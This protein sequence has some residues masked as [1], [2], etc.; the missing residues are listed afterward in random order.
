MTKTDRSNYTK[1]QRVAASR[2]RVYDALTTLDGLRGW[3]TPVVSGSGA[4]GGELKF[5]FE[6]LD[7]EIVM[8]VEAATRPTSVRW[9]CVGHS[10]LPEWAATTLDFDLVERSESTSEIHFQHLGLTPKLECYES[11]SAG[12]DYFLPSIASFVASGHGSPYTATEN[13]VGDVSDSSV[14]PS[15]HRRTTSR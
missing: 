12:W 14:R 6:G 1:V 5:G 9:R 10:S 13:A 8:Q 4:A 15:S 11:C 7:E 2:E 3:W